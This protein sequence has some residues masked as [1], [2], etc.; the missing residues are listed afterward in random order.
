MTEK[1]PES[2]RDTILKI[3]AIADRGIGGEK[4]AALQ[5]LRHW[6]EKYGLTEE[7]LFEETRAEYKFSFPRDPY[8]REIFKQCMFKALDSHHISYRISRTKSF[9]YFD[10][11]RVEY[12]DFI[13]LYEWYIRA[14]RRRAK[15]HMQIFTEAFI[16]RNDLFP[17][18]P[19]SEPKKPLTREE[20]E[21]CM[22]VSFVSA[23]LEKDSHLKALTQ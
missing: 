15:E 3:K 21:R 22:K 18:S 1:I 6:T 4:Q 7:D 13:E 10:L 11:T 5:A 8:E 17:S 12:A 9:V 20:W 19:N 14:F 2:V 16:Q 23:S